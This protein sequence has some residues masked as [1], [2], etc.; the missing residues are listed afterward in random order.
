MARPHPNSDQQPIELRPAQITSQ[1]APSPLLVPPV[2][3]ERRHDNGSKHCE[4]VDKIDY[5]LTIVAK[6]KQ[7]AI[8]KL[9]ACTNAIT[10]LAG[11]LSLS[12]LSAL[13]SWLFLALTVTYAFRPQLVSH[14]KA[15]GGSPS[16]ALLVLRVLSE[17]AGLMLLVVISAAFE[18]LRSILVA[19]KGGLRLLDYF[20][21]QE[22]SPVPGLMGIVWWRGGITMTTRI[23]SVVRLISIGLVPILNIV[24]MS[25]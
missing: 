16:S 2:A 18:E 4:S 15:I 8:A 19:R 14:L 10:I 17:V 9:R 23:R 6:L 7:Q 25:K 20:I 12:W 13:L 24:A 1:Q 21:L 5:I 11:Y 22:G 3:I